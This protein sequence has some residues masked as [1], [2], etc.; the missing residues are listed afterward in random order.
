MEGITRL[1]TVPKDFVDDISRMVEETGYYPVCTVFNTPMLINLGN[2]FVAQGKESPFTYL[3]EQGAPMTKESRA[4][5]RK[6]HPKAQVAYVY[7]TTELNAGMECEESA[8][9]DGELGWHMWEDYY[10]LEVVDPDTG[11]RVPKGER[12]EIVVTHFIHHTVPLIRFSLEDIAVN[13]FDDSVCEC[14]R[15]HRRWLHPIQGRTMDLFKVK[16]K[17]LLPWDVEKTIPKVPEAVGPFQIIADA[18]DM[19]ALK[20]KIETTRKL[21][22]EEYKGRVRNI[23]QDALGVPVK[24]EPVERGGLVRPGE[25]KITPFIDNR[26]ER[27]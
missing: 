8:N 6:A 15:T 4:A 14:G 27:K 18:W 21:P 19:D 20:V 16:G 5:I 17:D 2:A 7:T 22:D 9:K 24:P 26:P 13:D 1:L 11:K 3:N 25:W 23:L 10:V 12:G